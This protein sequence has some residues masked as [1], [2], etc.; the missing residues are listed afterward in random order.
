MRVH[1]AGSERSYDVLDTLDKLLGPPFVDTDDIVLLTDT[2]DAE[3]AIHGVLPTADVRATAKRLF[4]REAIIF[5]IQ[6]DLYIEATRDV[7]IETGMPESVVSADGL[8][9]HL[10][11]VLLADWGEWGGHFTSLR[12]YGGRWWYIDDFATAQPVRLGRTRRICLDLQ[13]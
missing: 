9:Y 13:A 11:M 8:I 10:T 5:G 7:A 1:G 4:A 3:Y 2:H 6:R 12:L